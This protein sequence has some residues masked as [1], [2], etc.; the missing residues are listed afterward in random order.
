MRNRTMVIVLLCAVAGTQALLLVFPGGLL[1]AYFEAFRPLLYGLLLAFCLVFGRK[2]ERTYPNK[3]DILMISCVGALAYINLLFIAGYFSGFGD[4]PM[5]TGARGAAG[6]AFSY[7]ATALMLEFF[8]A[9]VMTLSSGRLKPVFFITAVPLFTYCGIDNIRSVTAFSP[10]AKLDWVLTSLLP[11]LILNAFFCYT[12]RKGG[13]VGNL[14]FQTAYWS[15]FLFMPILPDVPRILD[16]I[17]IQLTVIVMFILLELREAKRR[18]PGKPA[19]AKPDA[20]PLWLLPP[21]ALLILCLTFGLGLLP[22]VPVAVAS[23]SMKDVFGKGSLVIV[24]KMDALAAQGVREGDVIQFRS[25]DISVLHRVVRIQ[26]DAYGSKEYV[27]KGDNN[28]DV[29]IY[30]VKPAQVV[31]RARWHI[32][33]IGYP[34]LLR[35][36]D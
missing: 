1:P 24:S 26:Y 4:N 2:D 28:P 9:K 29:D 33:Y 36:G 22:Y 3:P 32:P 25:G 7:L 27:T 20:H 8:R 34:A 13:L 5:D 17:L 10:G 15:V 23:N 31:G 6:N 19:D 30:P 18:E 12:A 16:A 35:I 21:A 14:V 11:L